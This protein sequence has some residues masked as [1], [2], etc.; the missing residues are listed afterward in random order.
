MKRT[1]Q[2]RVAALDI[3][4]A[5]RRFAADGDETCF[6]DIAVWAA[7]KI[8]RLLYCMIGSCREDREDAEQEIL[9]AL[10][11]GIKN[12]SFKSSFKT[13]FYRLCRNRARDFIRKMARDRRRLNRSG[14]LLPLREEPDPELTVLRKQESAAVTE[15]LMSLPPADRF[16]LYMKDGEG[17]SVEELSCILKL[18]GGTVKSRLHRVRKKAA[19]RA[20]RILEKE[21]EQ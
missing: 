20:A 6:R 13:Y 14:L 1:A 9:L 11:S 2:N 21:E 16:L 3:D 12:F 15:V 19:L 8:R 4:E 18:P 10:H 17:I 7:P 5:V